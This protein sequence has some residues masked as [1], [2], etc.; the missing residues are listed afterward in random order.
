[1][2]SST[3]LQFQSQIVQEI[4]DP[5]TSDLV[6]LAR[7]LGLRRIVCSL[8]QRYAVED[9]LVIL[10]GA[11]NSEE[12][13]AIGSQLSTMGV[14]NP[15]LRI[16]DYEMDKK[17]RQELYRK[18]GL[19]S[20]TSRILVVDLLVGDLPTSLISGMLV[21]HSEKVTPSST[22]AFIIRLY[23][24]TN[25]VGFLK[26]FSDQPEYFTAGMFPLRTIIKELHLRNVHIY[27]RF[28]NAVQEE[29]KRRKADIVEFHQPLNESMKSIHHAILQCM[30]ATL[31]ELKKSNTTLDLEDLKIENTYFRSFDA[32][33]RRQLDPVWHKVG[34]KTKQL[35][36]DLA[37][38]RR[39]LS[40]VV[41]SILV[42]PLLI[43][44]LRYLL[45]YDPV[46]FLSYLETIRAASAVTASGAQKK[47]HTASLW[48]MTDAA[49]VLFKYAR[50]RV[51]IQEKRAPTEVDL[52][53]EDE[54]EDSWDVLHELEG[55]TAPSRAAR[56]P[57][58]DGW[59]PWMPSGMQPVLEEL[60]KWKIL[61]DVLDE[62]EETMTS[63]PAPFCQSICSHMEVHHIDEF[64][65]LVAPGSNVTLI[66]AADQQT[67]TL[68]KDLLASP[69]QHADA[70]GREL[71]ENRLRLY[72][73]WKKRLVDVD[74]S[75]KPGTQTQSQVKA[76]SRPDNRGDGQ[77]S[78]ALKKKDAGR[79]F[80]NQNRRRVR[81]GAPA[82]SSQRQPQPST[83]ADGMDMDLGFPF[84][85]NAST[86]KAEPADLSTELD[87]QI[88]ASL[89]FDSAA[90]GND[91]YGLVQPEQLVIVR[92][93][94]DDSDD[95]LLSEIRPRWIIMFDP[96][97]DF[98][99]RVEVFR[100]MQPGLAL[101]VYFMSHHDTS[102][103]QRF[104]VGVRRE[105]EAFERLINERGSM[106]VVIGAQPSA[107][108]TTTADQLMAAISSRNAGGQKAYSDQPPT[109]LVDLREFRSSLPNLLDKANQLVV[110]LTLTVGDYILTPDICVERKSLPDLVQSFS[111]GRLYSQCELMS[112]HYKQPVLLIEF[113]ENKSF[114][115]ELLADPK[116][117]GPKPNDAKRGKGADAPASTKIDPQSVQTRLVVLTLAFPRLRIIWS[118]SPYTTA[119]IFA[120]LKA[121][122]PEPNPFQALAKGKEDGVGDA[123][124]GDNMTAEE[125]LRSLPGIGTK[126]YRYVMSK[127]ESI[128]ELCEMDLKSVQGLLGVEP[129]QACYDFLHA[130]E[131]A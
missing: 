129:G 12:D 85:S 29:L 127:V 38:L 63:H 36:S 131:R 16:I 56:V 13:V 5:S 90:Q 83:D 24:K 116:S 109:I 67:C 130:G 61:V 45:S 49:N 95:V 110:P 121:N 78:E 120:D 10:V 41:I 68:I 119:S 11:N 66:M 74:D 9:K 30:Q 32:L 51:Y 71:L 3:L 128:K 48:L 6:L 93:Y 106:H 77:M 91:S 82:S 76:S 102:E 124:G 118:S 34:P 50:N 59:K 117:G 39:L 8:L 97:Q 37:T 22:E 103:E 40:Q 55:N 53:K 4:Q 94:G 15:G 19:I 25:S 60:P 31:S 58:A 33:V 111:S 79:A 20:V 84:L 7:G 26:A 54:L 62:I 113:E 86:V 69:R 126:N 100:A 46:T 23:R 28:H 18:G 21:L 125:V 88:A 57:E 1:M 89:A 75:R 105:K 42:K 123:E 72:L 115:M 81:G 122:N 114:S 27:P 64:Y 52:T 80:A 87:A 108:M 44:Y 65:W 35:V 104:L 43:I 70:P 47:A 2:S 14:R 101:R 107:Y 17:D 92:P 98:L 96:N 73:F 112:A 99:R